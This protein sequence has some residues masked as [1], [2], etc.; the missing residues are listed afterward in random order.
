MG[1]YN[2]K[3]KTN[4]DFAELDQLAFSYNPRKYEI[5]WKQPTAL[6]FLQG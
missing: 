1:S 4:Y 3:G 2:K 6:E 5:K